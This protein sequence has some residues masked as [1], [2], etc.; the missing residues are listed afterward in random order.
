M[1]F[2]AIQIFAGMI[3]DQVPD[4]DE[5]SLE[6]ASNAFID[7]VACMFAG[8]RQEITLNSLRAT[9]SWGQGESIVIGHNAELA[10]PFAAMINAAAGHALDFDDYD[11]PANAHPS[12]VI[13]PALMAIIGDKSV[14]SVPVSGRSFLDA[15]IVGLEVMQRLGECMNMTHYRRG[16]LTTITLGSIGA[17]AACARLTRL[18]KNKCE[19]A[20]SLACSMASGLTNQGGFTAKQLNPGI[21]A[22]NAVMA[23]SLARAGV[24]ATNEAID[25]PISIARS[26]G[27]YDPEKFESTLDKVASP[28]SIKEFGIYTKPYPSCGYTGR[29]IDAAIAIHHKIR[30]EQFDQITAIEIAVPDYYLDLLIYALPENSNQAMF[31]AEYAVAYGLI[32]G[33]FDFNALQPEAIANQLVRRLCEKTRLKSK[34]PR[35]QNLLYDPRDP[36]SVIV[37]LNDGTVFQQSISEAIGSPANLL[38]TEALQTKFNDCLAFASIHHRTALIWQ[39]IVNI[40]SCHDVDQIFRLLTAG[41]NDVELKDTN[42]NPHQMP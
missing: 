37:E 32:Q 35:D 41:D 33:N 23:E 28:W 22:K 38:S 19:A 6:I 27:D 16:W 15:Y 20:L 3:S 36:D 25:G 31:S 18:D 5:E 17:A 2:N 14:F 24:T 39:S 9:S 26:M 4:H 34:T 11:L 40:Q 42:Q 29:I 7:T 1:K 30:A 13:F 12:V 10:A 21:A 8:S